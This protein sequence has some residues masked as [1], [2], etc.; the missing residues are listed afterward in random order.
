MDIA[1]TLKAETEALD[2]M[3]RD[4]VNL[5]GYA[6]ARLMWGTATQVYTM[7]QITHIMHNPGVEIV[8]KTLRD[9]ALRV[10]IL[11]WLELS[12]MPQAESDIQTTPEEKAA[13]ELFSDG[14]VAIVQLMAHT[15]TEVTAALR[16]MLD[17]NR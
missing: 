14:I 13:I 2:K 3:R 7:Q 1:Q 6:K 16:G 17:D 15:K 5:Y 8:L 12:G 4:Y 10:G 11:M 9:E